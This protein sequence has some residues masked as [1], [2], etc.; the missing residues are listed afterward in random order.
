MNILAQATQ[1]VGDAWTPAGVVFAVTAIAAVIAGTIIPSVIA[2]LNSWR[3]MREV[4]AA[5]A[6]AATASVQ[7]SNNT[8]TLVSLAQDTQAA[9]PGTVRK[10]AA[11]TNS[12]ANLPDVDEGSVLSTDMPLVAKPQAP[13]PENKPL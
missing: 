3:A 5:Q 6:I 2:L 1:P 7:A 12:D 4:K 10:L 13:T 9:S 11:I 8:A